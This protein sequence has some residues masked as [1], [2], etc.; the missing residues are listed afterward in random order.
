MD[1]ALR[2]CRRRLD[3]FLID[4]TGQLRAVVRQLIGTLLLRIRVQ[5]F[6]RAQV[7]CTWRC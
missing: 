2:G 7:S 5:L 4:L 6:A 1:A 3:I